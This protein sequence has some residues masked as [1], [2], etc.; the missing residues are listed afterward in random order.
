VERFA[1]E[2]ECCVEPVLAVDEVASSSLLSERESL[3][4]LDEAGA[5]AP[6]RQVDFPVRFSGG[7]RA[8][9]APAP[10]L[11]EHTEEVLSK[12]LGYSP[13]QIAEI[14]ASG[15]IT[16]PDKSKAAA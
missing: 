2:R 13:E 4:E 9:R 15:A 16:A 8:P 5:D 3:I 14:M 10:E 1:A 12:V 11:G 7:Y 6:V